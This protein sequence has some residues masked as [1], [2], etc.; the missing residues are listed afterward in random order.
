[1]YKYRGKL[2]GSIS[3]SQC[4]IKSIIYIRQQKPSVASESYAS[5][6]L[7]MGLSIAHEIMHFFV[8]FLAGSK[9]AMTPL[10]VSMPGYKL[11]DTVLGADFPGRVC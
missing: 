4:I 6:K 1:M 3:V 9:R 7:D 8:G 11:N 5:S 2:A 10:K